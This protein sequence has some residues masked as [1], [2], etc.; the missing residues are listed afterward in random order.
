M[1]WLGKVFGKDKDA[2]K[3]SADGRH[4]ASASGD[5]DEWVTL[6][7]LHVSHEL[8][9][10]HHAFVNM[11]WDPVRRVLLLCTRDTLW[12]VGRGWAHRRYRI[13]S[14]GRAAPVVRWMQSAP[15]ALVRTPQCI[16]LV[17]IKRGITYM[18]TLRLKDQY[19]FTAAAT[20]VGEAW[21][22]CARS[23]GVFQALSAEAKIT[24]LSIDLFDIPGAVMPGADSAASAAIT[25]IIPR[26]FHKQ[27]V[28]VYSERSGFIQVNYIRQEV[29]NRFM[30]PQGTAMTCVVPCSIDKYLLGGTRCGKVVVW[31]MNDAPKNKESLALPPMLVV[32]A[33]VPRAVLG[34]ECYGSG[35]EDIIFCRYTTGGA[36]VSAE[37]RPKDKLPGAAKVVV[38]CDGE[39]EWDGPV[40]G[41][42]AEHWPERTRAPSH[43]FLLRGGAIR[44]LAKVGAVWTVQNVAP[45]PQHVDVSGCLLVDPP[46]DV[47]PDADRAAFPYKVG[48]KDVGGRDPL[49]QLAVEHSKTERLLIGWGG[50]ATVAIKTAPASD[51]LVGPVP[52]F[53]T[54][55]PE[56]C[57]EA[58]GP[59][60]VSPAAYGSA[61]LT[62]SQGAVRWTDLATQST[63]DLDIPGYAVTCACHV[64]EPL[65]CVFFGTAD[66]QVGVLPLH[67]HS[68]DE[69]VALHPGEC[70]VVSLEKP[71]VS[72]DSIAAFHVDGQWTVTASYSVVLGH[73]A[74]PTPQRGGP[75]SPTGTPPMR[76]SFA[77]SAASPPASVQSTPKQRHHTDPVTPHSMHSHVAHSPPSAR[78]ARRGSD[79]MMPVHPPSSPTGSQA[80]S[81]SAL[82]TTSTEIAVLVFDPTASTDA[83]TPGGGATPAQGSFATSGRQASQL[84]TAPSLPDNSF[85]SAPRLLRRVGEYVVSDGSAMPKRA[86]V[87]LSTELVCQ[88]KQEMTDEADATRAL[89]L[90]GGASPWPTML[91]STLCDVVVLLKFPHGVFASDDDSL[92]G[93]SVNAESFAKRATHSRRRHRQV[94]TLPEEGFMQTRLKDTS[95]NDALVI[96]ARRA[97]VLGHVAITIEWR[98]AGIVP[99]GDAASCHVMKSAR[100]DVVPVSTEEDT[101]V[102]V[103][104]PWEGAYAYAVSF[105]S[106]DCYVRPR[107]DEVFAAMKA[108]AGTPNVSNTDEKPSGQVW[109]CLGTAQAVIYRD[110]DAGS[111][112]R[113]AVASAICEPDGALAGA[114]FFEAPDD[115][116]DDDAIDIPHLE[117]VGRDDKR[118]LTPPPPPTTYALHTLLVKTGHETV[119]QVKLS[120]QHDP[121]CPPLKVG[122]SSPFTM[123][124][125]TYQDPAE[126]V[127]AVKIAEMPR[128][129]MCGVFLGPAAVHIVQLPLPVGVAAPLLTHKSPALAKLRTFA[130]DVSPPRIHLIVFG[131]QQ[132]VVHLIV[133][134]DDGVATLPH[135]P[136]PDLLHEAASGGPFMAVA[137][138][139]EIRPQV[140][141][142][143]MG[144]LTLKGM[145]KGHDKEVREVDRLVREL[146]EESFNDFTARIFTPTQ[147]DKFDKEREKRRKELL[148]SSSPAKAGPSGAAGDAMDAMDRNKQLVNE[149]GQKVGDLR[150]VTANMDNE[151]SNFLSAIE[152]YNKK[153]KA[154]SWF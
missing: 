6:D 5:S 8:L 47:I 67:A 112:Q 114:M 75:A 13:K 123:K 30:P 26:M 104:V 83:V 135:A 76:H 108:V 111:Q 133:T 143:G 73:H 17:D 151:A 34:V 93:S 139:P 132:R 40:C 48:G 82:L 105:A 109:K 52:A 45:F 19:T 23:D 153:Q 97:D 16:T 54:P 79:R 53:E 11:A 90:N 66:A 1:G 85:Q 61:L 129:G 78:S 50:G 51:F 21:V 31:K 39:D 35:S 107:P 18:H 68:R 126:R 38:L 43:M 124:P 92:A 25:E 41:T 120:V 15:V 9:H 57:D 22:L 88:W 121:R 60:Q 115:D 128:F 145:F 98:G 64:A 86:G 130:V 137:A 101:V 119:Q 24:K 136:A 125:P 106:A 44:V 122:F 134:Q 127:L 103:R 71:G 69:R 49:A 154:K 74:P 148:G 20:V 81:V 152:E 91:P 12:V 144:M 113:H 84:S 46:G 110:K 63:R 142:P 117:V 65:H 102:A 3:P 150:D 100:A 87:L 99:E 36:V 96:T 2:K 131:R 147:R 80:S 33:K 141:A 7:R 77:G 59:V 27:I 58:A 32:P 149:R 95:G 62:C 28:V 55:A 42:A 4:R 70:V 89:L 116:D 94:P 29:L 56:G 14:D 72:V 10:P 146:V 140:K 118:N 37:L 138:A